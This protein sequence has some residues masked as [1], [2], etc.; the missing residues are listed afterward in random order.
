MKGKTSK[1]VSKKMLWKKDLTKSQNYPLFSIKL[2]MVESN[3]K[4]TKLTNNKIL[5]KYIKL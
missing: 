3:K 4:V 1:T 5:I 2:K